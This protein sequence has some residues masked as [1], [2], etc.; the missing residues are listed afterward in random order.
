M[1]LQNIRTITPLTNIGT[2]VGFRLGAE[3][4]STPTCFQQHLMITRTHQEM[5]YLNTTS[6]YFAAALALNAPMEGFP[7]NDL[8]NQHRTLSDDS[9][10]RVGCV[11]DGVQFWGKWGQMCDILHEEV[12]G[13]LRY[14][15]AKKHCRKF[16]PLRVGHTS[17]I[18]VKTR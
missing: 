8:R 18:W 9:P 12:K 13:W 2:P 1:S 16:E 5:R 17:H 14:K 15:M 6:L 7:W 11:A 3:I 10:N 4:P